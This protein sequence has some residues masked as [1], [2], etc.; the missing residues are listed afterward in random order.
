LLNFRPNGD[1]GSGSIHA[2][3]ARESVQVRLTVNW[4]I[5]LVMQQRTGLLPAVV[6]RFG[7][8]FMP[9]ILAGGLYSEVN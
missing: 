2:G 1:S 4:R 3:T 6:S 9:S 5:A 8:G 7:F